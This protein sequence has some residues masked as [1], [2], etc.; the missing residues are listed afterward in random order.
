VEIYRGGI[1]DETSKG[2]A[3]S[4]KCWYN[5]FIGV[6]YFTLKNLVL[7]RNAGSSMGQACPELRGS[8]IDGSALEFC[9]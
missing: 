3:D 7:T 4:R 1:M 8:D 9:V 6:F 5:I 2:S